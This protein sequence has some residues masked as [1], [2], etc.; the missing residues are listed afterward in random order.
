MIHDVVSAVYRE[1]YKVEVTFDDGKK[2]IVDFVKYLRR[3]GVFERFKDMDFFR[4]FT[5]N[6]ELGTLTWQ[7]EIDIA[8]ETLYAD[9]TGSPL[10]DW[11]GKKSKSVANKSQRAV[12][13]RR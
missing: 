2:G 3:G 6:K 13:S 9:A 1:G 10:P 11:V 12:N 8:P 7:N 4:S 5:I